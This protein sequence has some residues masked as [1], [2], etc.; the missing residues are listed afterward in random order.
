MQRNMVH[1]RDVRKRAK[2]GSRALLGDRAGPLSGRYENPD[3]HGLSF[4]QDQLC[5]FEQKA[6][7][8]TFFLEPTASQG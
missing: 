7:G 2:A 3:G 4:C 5:V 1:R 6:D 8:G